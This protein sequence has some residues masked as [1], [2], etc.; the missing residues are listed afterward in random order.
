MQEFFTAHATFWSDAGIR[1]RMCIGAVLLIASFFATYFATR[2]T[3]LSSGNVVPDL[4]LD[5]L[6]VYDVG[7]FF[8]QGAF[9]FILIL[10]GILLLQ[11]A[12]I[13]FTLE[14]T[15]LFFM[16]RSIFMTMTHLAPPTTAYYDFVQHEHHVREVLFTISSGNDMFFSGHTGF[17]FL[18]A[19]IFWKKKWF[20]YFF[21]LCSFIGGATSILGHV[22]YS[23]DVF[24]SFFIAFGVFE[25]CRYLFKKEQALTQT[26][27]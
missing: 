9:A 25:L 22:H 27:S 17:P 11:P 3:N 23:I 19:L 18:L 6:P 14:N 26:P 7:I 10:I 20:R 2:Y 21:L 12:F 15:A 24:S 4:L 8:F 16:T 1:R 13:P 5:H